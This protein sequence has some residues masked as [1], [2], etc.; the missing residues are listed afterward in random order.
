MT[1]DTGPVLL[2]LAVDIHL[3]L[4]AAAETFW[5]PDP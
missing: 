4:S 5:D 1:N 2:E 3:L